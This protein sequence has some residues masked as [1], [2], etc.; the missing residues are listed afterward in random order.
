MGDPD[1]NS[2]NISPVPGPDS[3]EESDESEFCF[4]KVAKIKEEI[5]ALK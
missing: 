1:A 2:G 4:D 3:G 5:N